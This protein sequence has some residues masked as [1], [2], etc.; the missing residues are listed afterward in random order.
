MNLEGKTS[1][2]V[3]E[4]GRVTGQEE[5]LQTPMELNIV[6]APIPESPPQAKSKITEQAGTGPIALGA[7]SA[8]ELEVAASSTAGGPRRSRPASSRSITSS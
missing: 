5:A 7:L 1:E 3:L 2:K 6:S 4:L 8:P